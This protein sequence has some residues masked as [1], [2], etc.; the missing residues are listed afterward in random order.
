MSSRPPICS[1]KSCL[2]TVVTGE[3]EET[4]L[5]YDATNMTSGQMSCK[6]ICYLL[7]EIKCAK[8]EDYFESLLCFEYVLHMS[9][10]FPVCILG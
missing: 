3:S 7:L 10:S 2:L 9:F 1:C 8:L 5:I 6:Y 4:V